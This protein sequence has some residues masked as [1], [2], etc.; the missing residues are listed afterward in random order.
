MPF[1]NA[2]SAIELWKAVENWLKINTIHLV[3]LLDI[4]TIFG[5][6][7]NDKLIDKVIMSL[8]MVIYNNRKKYHAMINQTEEKFL[9]T[10]EKVYEEFNN[11]FPK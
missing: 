4:D 6:H 10:W 3:K 11:M 2:R 9:E 5:Q 8:K 7:S 1:W